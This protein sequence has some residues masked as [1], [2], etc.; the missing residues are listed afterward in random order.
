MV[1]VPCYLKGQ[2]APENTVQYGPIEIGYILYQQPW[3]M[4]ASDRKV[5]NGI[6]AILGY[7][8]IRFP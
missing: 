2:L 1:I 7:Y 5:L 6:L 3:G 4:L 8:N